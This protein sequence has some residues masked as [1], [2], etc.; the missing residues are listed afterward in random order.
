MSSVTLRGI[1]NKLY[2]MFKAIATLKGITVQKALEEAIELWIKS[3]SYVLTESD[4]D[5]VIEYLRRNPA[6][7]FIHHA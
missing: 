6:E 4:A 5:A 1:N 7:P 3:N 2:K